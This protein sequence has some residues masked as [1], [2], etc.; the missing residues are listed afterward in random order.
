MVTPVLPME[1]AL[2]DKYAAM[3]GVLLIV[4][5][6]GVAWE[7]LYH[8]LQQW[9][10]DKDWPTLLGLLLGI[11]EGALA[12]VVARSGALGAT[13]DLRRCVPHRLHGRL[14]RDLAVRERSHAAVHGALA[15]SRRAAGVSAVPLTPAPTA[16]TPRREP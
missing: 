5:V 11:P 7:L 8:L 4:G 3:F 16:V 1:A 15:L 13:E 2:A 12:F 9:R 10:W 6:V 14:A